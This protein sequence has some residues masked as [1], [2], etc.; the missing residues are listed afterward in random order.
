MWTRLRKLQLVKEDGQGLIEYA[1]IL[2]LVAVVV[3]AILLV[4]GPTVGNVFS[5]IVRNLERTGISIELPGGGDTVVITKADYN[6]GDQKLKLRATSDG[7]ADPGITLTASPGGVMERESTYYK[8]E[9]NLSGCPCNVTV[10]SSGGG[11][12]SVT[13]GP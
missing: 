6:S 9:F 1:L 4:M 7:G 8:L 10:T 11:S 12:D 2:V 5:N 13:V 3:I